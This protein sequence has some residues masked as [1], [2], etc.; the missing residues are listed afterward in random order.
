V[1]GAAILLALA[2]GGFDAKAPGAFQYAPWQGICYRG[3]HRAGFDEELCVAWYRPGGKQPAVRIEVDRTKT[4]FFVHAT[5]KSCDA[6]IVERKLDPALAGADRAAA[7]VTA[8]REAWTEAAA[9]CSVRV[10]APVFDRATLDK[11][12]LKSD[13]LRP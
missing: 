9:K 8:L 13:G 10:A 11:L 4:V 3:K 12:L 6:D 2:S 5:V 1:S 7:F